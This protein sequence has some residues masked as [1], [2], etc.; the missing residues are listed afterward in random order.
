MIK[1]LV[2]AF[3]ALSLGGAL[4]LVGAGSANADPYGS[5]SN[6]PYSAKNYVL[7]LWQAS[8]NF[9]PKFPQSFVADTGPTDSTSL[10]TLDGQANTCGTSYQ[11]DLYAND[12]TTAALITG[13]VLNGGDESW[14]GGVYT[15]SFS[16]HIQTAA[17]ATF[18]T[19]TYPDATPATCDKAGSLPALPT[20]QPGL[21]F[22]WSSSGLTMIASLTYGRA[23]ATNAERSHTYSAPESA[24]G[25]QSTNQQAPCY[26]A[27]TGVS[28]ETVVW[29]MPAPNNGS[30]ATYPQLGV[31]QYKNEATQTLDV[32]V[33]TTCGTQ[34]QVDVYLQINGSVD[35]TAAIDAMF[36]NGLA[37]PNGAQ[38]GRYLA[39]QSG[40]PGVG[41]LGYA[42]K[43]VKNADCVTP[44]PTVQACSSYGSVVSHDLTGWDTSDTRATGHYAVTVG[45]LHIW[46]DGATSTDKVAAYYPT[47]FALA[48]AGTETVGASLDY[49]ATTGIAPG[50]QQVVDFNNDGTPDGILVG[51]AVYGG[52]DWW[53]NS[54]GTLPG[55]PTLPA[56]MTTGGSGS[57]R[58]GT[59]NEWLA[60]YPN[61]H[62]LAVG[63]S[64]GSG[65]HADGIVKRITLGCVNYTFVGTPPLIDV[66]AGDPTNTNQL[67]TDSQ[68][69]GGVITVIITPHVSYQ[70][71]GPNGVVP[72]NGTTGKTGTLAPG[73]YTVKV[74]ADTGYQLTSVASFPLTITAYDGVCGQLVDHPIV[75]PAVTSTQLGCT[76]DG[77]YTLSNDLNAPTGVIWTVDGSPVAPG[78]YSVTSARTVKIHANPNGPNYGFSSG[79]QQDW[80]LTFVTA[81]LCSTLPT[82]ALHDG[83]LAFT[84][85]NPTGLLVLSV[86]LALFGLALMRR[87]H[88]VR[89]ADRS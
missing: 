8:A 58:H 26:K 83:T 29:S 17:C 37:G 1:R 19:P 38:D 56:S 70:I 31:S 74:A 43:F 48:Q 41:G 86:F 36:Q 84:G 49:T 71:T 76:T 28:Y 46:T 89:M 47:D 23:F 63:F 55:S 78:T 35:N 20:N 67:C 33:P 14:P 6:N 24:L 10:D 34:Y 21:T 3:L 53:L 44:P 77:S 54:S 64:L 2:A 39:G 11:V 88:V 50:L 73:D 75:T 68:L 22:S 66:A 61:A 81:A 45:G 32:A 27:P 5:D 57:A 40:N 79:Q 80:T 13:R 18:V 7:V 60:L 82:L 52:T 16:K 72:F 62:I 25:Y 59:L 65:V 51:E 30:S 69:V 4:A 12:S 9:T 42:W 87:A 15:P 85:S